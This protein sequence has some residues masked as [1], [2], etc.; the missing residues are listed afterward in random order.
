M[1]F[2]R[3]TTIWRIL[4]GDLDLS[5]LKNCK[6]ICVCIKFHNYVI[7]FE[8]LQFNHFVTFDDKDCTMVSEKSLNAFEVERLEGGDANNLGFLV[9]EPSEINCDN[10]NSRRDYILQKI[11]EMELTRPSHN[12]ERNG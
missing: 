2:G 1:A 5:T 7:N 11:K 6:I 3:L 8:D 10:K 12:I 9:T 4:R